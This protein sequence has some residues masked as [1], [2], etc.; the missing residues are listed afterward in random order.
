M[1][2]SIVPRE[3][4]FFELFER[5]GRLVEETLA[6]LSKSLLE[7]S[8]RHPR[9]RDLEHECDGVTH[10]I[11]NRI[12]RTFVTPLERE[13][14]YQLAASLDDIVDLAEE[15]A[16]KIELY[17]VGEVTPRARRMGETLA[18][19]GHEISQALSRLED[20]Q[21]LEPHRLAVHRLENEGDTLVREA[22]ADLFA[23]EGSPSDLI[24]WKDLYDLLEETMDRIEQVANVLGAIAIKNA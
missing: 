1:K 17:G 5:Q 12:N 10:E 13:D 4:R 9:L 15:V 22:L 11:Y 20:F 14:I 21:D 2:W 3:R 24:K 6:E 7:G 16:D 8:S 23:R 18:Q 19:G